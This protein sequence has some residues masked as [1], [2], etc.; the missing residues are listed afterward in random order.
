[1]LKIQSNSDCF[2]FHLLFNF[3]D[4]FFVCIVLQQLFKLNGD[5]FAYALD[6]IMNAGTIQIGDLLL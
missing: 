2:K 6:A 3:C 1:M 5:R 4:F